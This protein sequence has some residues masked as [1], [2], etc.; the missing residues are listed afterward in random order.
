MLIFKMK[1]KTTLGELVYSDLIIPSKKTIFQ[2]GQEAGISQQLLFDFVFNGKQ[3]SDDILS[4][5]SIFFKKVAK[6]AF[7]PFRHTLTSF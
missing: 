4:K 3:L 2:I 6:C 1:N 5:I 7:F